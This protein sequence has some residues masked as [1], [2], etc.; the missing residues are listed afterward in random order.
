MPKNNVL[1]GLDIGTSKVAAVIAEVDPEGPINIIG[2]GETPSSGLRKG[3]IIDIE[4]T[5]RAAEKAADQAEQMSGIAIDAVLVGITGPHISSVNNRGVV[6]VTGVGKEITE[7]DAQRVVQAAQV[8]T[9]PA[10]RQIIHVLPRQFIVDG[11]DGIV[12]P[13]GMCG[14]RLEVE[15]NILTGAA[16]SIQNT[17]KTVQ[18]AGL[19]VH[20]LVFNG[21]AS[22]EAV[23]LPAEKELGVVLVDIGAGTTELAIYEQKNLWY[24]SVLPVGGDH[25]T[26]DLAVGLRTPIAAAEK[27]K[28]EHGCVREASMPDDE[29]IDVPSVGGT[30]IRQ[31]SKK[32]LAAII[33]PRVQEILSLIKREIQRSGYKGLLPGGVVITGGSSLLDGLLALAEEMLEMP[34]RRGQPLHIEGLV[35]LVCTPQYSS[36]IGILHYGAKNLAAFQ[37]A[38]AGEFFLG[39]VWARL[40]AWF[41]EIF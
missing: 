22:A 28:K 18:R 16:A 20:A 17:L 39:S 24:A 4:C 25:I 5:A 37:A 21:L 7:E 10:E 19:E 41:K 14:S 32:F 26:N 30:E 1:A 8:I 31:V 36:A 33:E 11:Y 27:I 38:P 29:Y 3:T 34:V 2:F 15:T 40:T 13:V 12:D 9:L 35:D 6:A 23:L